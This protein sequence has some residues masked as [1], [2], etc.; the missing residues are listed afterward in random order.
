MKFLS[1]RWLLPTFFLCVLIILPILAIVLHIPFIDIGTLEHL[2]KNVLPRYVYGSAIILFGTLILCLVLGLVSAYLISF[3][4]FFGSKFFEWFLILPLAIPSY[5]M[6]FVWIDLFEFK[7]LIP[8]FL[9]IERRIGIMNSYGV[10]VILSFALYPY[11]YFFAKNS[12]S[13]GLGSIILSAK[14][15][16]ASNLKTFF[17]IIL[18]FCRIG[19]ISSLLLVAMETLSDYGLVAYFGVDT[20]SA[21]IFR[22]WGSGGDEVSAVALSVALLVF[23]ALL[24]LLEKIQ[25]GKK[26]FT[27]NV[28]LPT[29]KDEL[30]GIKAFLAFLWCFCLAF[31]AFIVPI[32]WLVYWAKFDFIQSFYNILTPSLYSLSVSLISSFCIVF[33]AFYL[34]FV[35]RLNNTKFSKTM[36]WLAT[37]GY[38]LPG[39]VVAVGILV[40]LGVLNWIF[41]VFSFEYAVGGGFLVLFFGY[42]VRFLASGIFAT[43]SGFERISQ[44]IDY[45]NLTLKIKPFKIFACIHFPLMKYYLALAVVIICVD[46]L[47]ELPI[48]TILSPSGFQTLSSLVFAYS[49]TE[50]IYNVALPSLIIVLFGIIPTFLM[51]YLQDKNNQRK[52]SC[53]C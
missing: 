45:A 43:Q 26:S 8:T 38:S 7:G 17:R 44:H 30:K 39:A 12:F 28:F 51:H 1:L 27:Q 4:K 3:Y 29:P 24:M 42:F 41:D 36:L 47:K 49:E 6:G 46:I 21:G 14:I 25:R 35:I 13:H 19:I 53:K 22:T 52:N 15:L 10:I 11:V 48:S 34:C 16:K 33:V 9:G 37:L 5:V 18:P 31:L 20:F 23:I 2:S 32:I 50:L 40:I